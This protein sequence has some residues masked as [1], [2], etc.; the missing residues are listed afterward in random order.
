MRFSRFH[1]VTLCLLSLFAM[2]WHG[3][4][5]EIVVT[6]LSDSGGVCPGS[7]CTLRAALEAA[8]PGDVIRAE[9]NG[10]IALA[11]TLVV[12]KALTI[13]GAGLTLDGGGQH[14]I[15]HIRTSEAVTVDGLTFIDGAAADGGAL[16]LLSG[17]RVTL[18]N[19]E[20][21]GNRGRAGGAI[22]SNEATLSI[23]RSRFFENIASDVGGA[24]QSNQSALFVSNTVFSENRAD[25]SDENTVG[26]RGG[27]VNVIGGT[28]D[29]SRVSFIE[30]R[31]LP[32]AGDTEPA[33]AALRVINSAVVRVLNST[34]SANQAEQGNGA[35]WVLDSAVNLLHV[36]L[37][38]N[39]QTDAAL[40]MTSGELFVQN[41][42]F[43]GNTSADCRIN[44]AAVAQGANNL[45]LLP[46]PDARDIPYGVLLI[47]S[48]QGGLTPTNALLSGSNAI[49]A[50]DSCVL[51]AAFNG[52][53]FGEAGT[54]L[55][56]DQRGYIRPIGAACDLGAYEYESIPPTPAPTASANTLPPNRVMHVSAPQQYLREAVGGRIGEFTVTLDRAP[57]PGELVTITPVYDSAQLTVEPDVR[58]LSLD[59]WNTGRRFEIRII[60]DDRVEGA[61]ESLITFRVSSNIVDSPFNGAQ[62]NNRVIVSIE[63]ND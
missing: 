58:R 45:G 8:A 54:P 36:T 3:Y 7:S 46:C 44:S 39:I 31:V 41:S 23:R 29:L 48:D 6:S 62:P 52:V 2:T 59:N 51:P 37:A 28:A 11:E 10:V 42:V 21:S 40:T 12:D 35:I 15:M 17:A 43:A 18:I 61:H 19:V 63:D 38:G 49:D 14:R 5:A 56:F 24:I 1:A 32:F 57:V 9:A 16:L 22:S 27:A 60:D 26:A 50:A 47:A 25:G 34:F 30:N 4:A 53:L 33:G 13:N 20:M 55:L